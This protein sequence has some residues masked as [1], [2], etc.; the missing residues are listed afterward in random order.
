MPLGQAMHG[1]T[2]KRPARR[3]E[4]GVALVG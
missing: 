2:V 1:Q 3:R 4:K